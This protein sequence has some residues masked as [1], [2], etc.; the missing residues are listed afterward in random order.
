MAAGTIVGAGS[1]VTKSVDKPGMCIAGNP[2]KMVCTA[3]AYMVKNEKF[4]VNLNNM[5]NF[6]VRNYF[7]AHEES[8]IKKKTMKQ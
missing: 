4:F 1:V 3:K 5:S 6:E 7:E 8:L 2:A